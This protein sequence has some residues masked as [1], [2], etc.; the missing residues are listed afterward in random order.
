[1][2]GHG[3]VFFPP[4]RRFPKQPRWKGHG[5][6]TKGTEKSTNLIGWYEKK[7]LTPS[8]N[9][10]NSYRKS[11]ILMVSARKDGDFPASYASCWYRPVVP[12]YFKRKQVP[13]VV[14][15][16]GWGW[17]RS[18]HLHTC[19]ML[20]NWSGNGL[21]WVGLGMMTFLALAHMWHATQLMG[22]GVGWGG[23]DV[24]GTCTHVTCYA[25]DRVMGWGGLG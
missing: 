17:W 6:P 10:T 12:V 19:D 1:M 22:G 14:V 18:W 21:G 8:G 7:Q 20:R 23:D 9:L 24:L 5:L 16:V 3:S 13:V 25:T 11:T 2:P 4:P 15:G